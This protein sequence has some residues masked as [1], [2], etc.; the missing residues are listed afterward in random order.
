MHESNSNICLDNFG[1]TDVL[2]NIINEISWGTFSHVLF[3]HMQ[4]R[5]T[6]KEEKKKKKKTE[7]RMKKIFNYLYYLFWNIEATI[8]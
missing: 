3:F 2:Q 5:I 6:Q 1:F 8:W 4:W 7:Y